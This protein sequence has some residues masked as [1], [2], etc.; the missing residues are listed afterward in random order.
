MSYL[1][2]VIV[3]TKDRYYHL[4]KL[5]KLINSFK[6]ND[7]ELVLQDN[8]E[9]NAEILDFLNTQDNPHIKYAH[10]S[11][12][13]PI[14]LNADL[15][16]L[17]SSGEFICFIGDDDGV[18]KYIIECAKWMKKNRIDVVVPST[19]AYTWP[20]YNDLYGINYSGKLQYKKITNKITPVDTKK[21]LIDLMN[22]GFIDRGNLPLSYHG[23]V[24][25]SIMDKIYAIGNS[26][27]PGPS[28][29]I[30]NGVAL[31]LLVTNYYNVNFPIIISGASKTHGGG[32][33]KMKNRASNIEDL[34]FLP[35][36]TKDLWEKNIPRI[37]TGETI[38][39][40]S[41]IKALR[42]MG[43]QDLI[44]QVNFEFMY[45]TFIAFHF[46]T[47][48]KYAYNLSK[49]KLKLIITF[50]YILIVR[51]SKAFIRLI[52]YKISGK[53][54][55]QKVYSDIPNIIKCVE[56][57]HFNFQKPPF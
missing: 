19:I 11:Q 3:P 9:N 43:R 56:V 7:I 15:A 37:W 5:I 29:D 26:Y 53:L 2:S 16:I 48:S 54:Y 44:N 6:S 38:W 4:K 25:R 8:T 41:A 45:A 52:Y 39:C 12:Q 28:P 51:Y 42:Y 13:I 33:R 40:E 17:N 22:R 18:T 31:S 57:L 47:I 24:S 10:N 46:S 27:F 21:C 55:G 49:N 23:I 35:T 1:L 50:M 32:I 30:A 14:S 36:N 20:D 34:P